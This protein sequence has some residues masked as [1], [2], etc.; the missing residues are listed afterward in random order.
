MANTVDGKARARATVFAATAPTA[1]VGAA[2][3]PVAPRC[4]PMVAFDNYEGPIV[5]KPICQED[6]DAYNAARWAAMK[7]PVHQTVDRLPV[8]SPA[9]ARAAGRATAVSMVSERLGLRTKLDALPPG[10]PQWSAIR[11]RLDFI[12]HDIGRQA[13][14]AVGLNDEYEQM[15]AARQAAHEEYLRYN[16]LRNDAHAGGPGALEAAEAALAAAGARYER[17]S[18]R[19]SEIE[20][21]ARLQMPGLE[22]D[23]D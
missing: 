1:K 11:E 19:M 3:Q 4:T 15:A 9:A 16:T 8:V 2:H 6:F 20:M 7:K 12:D 14:I 5:A 13:R 23:D 21:L 10:S 22:E 18:A 17:F